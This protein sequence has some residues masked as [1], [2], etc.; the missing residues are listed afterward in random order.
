MVSREDLHRP[1]TLVAGS[2]GYPAGTVGLLV[3][4]LRDGA[5]IEIERQGDNPD[6][7]TVDLD[8]VTVSPGAS[9][10]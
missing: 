9:A 8:G 7:I 6:L 4:C 3:A 2:S 10:A 1:V 5:V